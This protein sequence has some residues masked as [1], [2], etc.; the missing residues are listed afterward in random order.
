MRYD[1]WCGYAALKTVA[2]VNILKTL[3][4]L[5]IAS[6]DRFIG[7]SYYR[8]AFCTLHIAYEYRIK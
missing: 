6:Y 4:R 1:S 7:L 2:H 8:L 3:I 5:I